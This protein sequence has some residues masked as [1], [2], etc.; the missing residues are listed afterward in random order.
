MSSPRKDGVTS[1]DS[2]QGLE[3]P[4]LH[5][6]TLMGFFT[7]VIAGYAQ[8][9]PKD[10]LPDRYVGIKLG[11][12]LA[13]QRLLLFP[14]LGVCM[15]Y[16]ACQI[17]IYEGKRVRGHLVSMLLSFGCAS[18]AFSCARISMMY[19][20]W[21]LVYAG[22]GAFYDGRR[23]ALYSDGAPMYRWGDVAR[24]RREAKEAREERRREHDQA[25]ELRRRQYDAAVAAM[26]GA[27]E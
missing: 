10:F 9:T 1:Y 26:E 4:A 21:F 13:P 8:I 18:V 22:Y 25:L 23:L 7:M 11:T 14:A 16:A 20:L 17:Q 27:K 3:T 19:W 12:R 24:I 2:S 6:S 5:P 15:S